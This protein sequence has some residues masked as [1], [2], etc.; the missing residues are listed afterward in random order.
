MGENI[1]AFIARRAD[2]INQATNIKLSWGN[3]SS[4]GEWLAKVSGVPEKL[5]TDEFYQAPTQ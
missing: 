4:W 3:G 5:H 1:N 2:I